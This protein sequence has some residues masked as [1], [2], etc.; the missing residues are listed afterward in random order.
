VRLVFAGGAPLYNPLGFVETGAHVAVWLA[1]ALIIGWRASLGA[2]HI[3]A[4]AMNVLLVLAVVTMTLAGAA[5]AMSFW[6]ERATPALT[7]RDT[8]GFVVPSL[9]FW[10]HWLFWRARGANLQTRVALAASTLTLAAAITT[11]A[12]R[13][14]ALPEWGSAVIGA[15]SF[16]AAVGANFAPVVVK[17]EESPRLRSRGRVPSPAASPRAQSTEA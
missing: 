12:M 13:A 5:W 6:S 8:L 2:T 3:R 15:F 14:N 10:G 16:A 17:G 4:G 1:A 9:A 11:E 7:L